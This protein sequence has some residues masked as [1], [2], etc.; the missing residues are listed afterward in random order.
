MTDSEK[1][2]KLRERIKQLEKT[3]ADAK[4]LFHSG[5]SVSEIYNRLTR[6]N[7]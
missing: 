3:I 6:E 7:K 5:A 2:E 4:E 1:L